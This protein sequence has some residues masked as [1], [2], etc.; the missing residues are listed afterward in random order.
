MLK[1]QNTALQEKFQKCRQYI[2]DGVAIDQRKQ[3]DGF[4]SQ[5]SGKKASEMMCC[6][7]DLTPAVSVRFTPALL[8]ELCP[9]SGPQ[10][11]VVITYQLPNQNPILRA[12]SV[13]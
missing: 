8:P 10:T 12:S 5:A 7:P 4:R 2:P 11:G 6:G 9:Q 1:I 13:S 3:I